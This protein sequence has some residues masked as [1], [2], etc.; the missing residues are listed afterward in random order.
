MDEVER[1]VAGAEEFY[2]VHEAVPRF[3]ITPGVC[4]DGL[5]ALLDGRGYRRHSPVSVRG[6]ATARVLGLER[7]LKIRVDERPTRAWFDTWQAVNGESRAEWEMLAR[8]D[9][10]SVYVSAL[11]GDDTVAVGRAVADGG[12]AGVFS[13]ATLPEAR[14]KGAARN[15]LSALAGWADANNADRMY[16]QVECGN[17]A[18]ARLYERAGFAEMCVYHYRSA[19]PR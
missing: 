19:G 6:A 9:L 7:T 10:P 15:V 5:D 2:A 17:E 18:A 8:V 12:W 13:M 1:R 11:V 14:G 3:Q 4:P 16:L